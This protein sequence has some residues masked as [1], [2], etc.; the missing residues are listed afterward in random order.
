M[1]E[2]SNARSGH[3]DRG[4]EGLFV[5]SEMLNEDIQNLFKDLLLQE[6]IDGERKLLQESG[7]NIDEK[8]LEEFHKKKEELFAFAKENKDKL[9]KLDVNDMASVSGGAPL[10]KVQNAI[11]MVASMFVAL[12]RGNSLLNA[13]INSVAISLLTNIGSEIYATLSGD[14][15]PADG[16]DVDIRDFAPAGF[17][18]VPE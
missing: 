3:N 7:L 11:G 15:L 6:D 10:F 4:E 1:P 8:S 5:P 9:Q 16:M 17:D 12:I 13:G 14:R 2:F 18:A